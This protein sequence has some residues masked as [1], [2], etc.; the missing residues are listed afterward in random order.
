MNEERTK[1]DY[2]GFLPYRWTIEFDG[3]KISPIPEFE[4]NATWIDK[5]TNEDGFL[6]PPI[7]HRVEVDPGT[8]KPWKEIPR[9]GRA[10]HLHRVPPSHEL[11]LFEPGKS[12]EVRKGPESVIIQLLAYLFG[13]R[14]QFYDW[15]VD[16]RLPIT[17]RARTHGIRFTAKTAEGFLSHCY[18]TWKSWGEGEQKLITNV[19]FMHT[20]APSYEWDWERFTI[21][22]MVLDACWRLATQ[23]SK[24]QPKDYVPHGKRIEVLCQEF[25]IPSREDLIKDIVYLRNDLFHETLWDGR[26]PGTAVSSDSF[27]LPDHL[28]RLNQRLIMALLGYKTPYIQT[29]W[30]FLGNYS[31]DQP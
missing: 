11:C 24:I 1:R 28:R 27:I 18:K 26:Q 5:Y 10:A 30:W 23:L 21:E 22:Y 15:W 4:E 12:E 8:M 9:T 25:R 31:F 19:L 2:F 16:S 17:E 29:K 13:V 6:Y 14:L 20:R 7:E 3:G